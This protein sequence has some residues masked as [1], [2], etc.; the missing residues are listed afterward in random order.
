MSEIIGGGSEG[1]ASAGGN[2]I[3]DGSVE[4]FEED[5]LKMSL[6]VPVIVDFWAPWCGPCKQLTPALEKAVN[7]AGGSVRLV[8]IDIDKNQMLASQLRIQS[9]PT[10]YAFFQAQP[11]DGFMGA[12]PESEITAF[13]ERIKAVAANGGAPGSEPG[14]PDS[15][16][17]LAA[18]GEAFNAG[19]ISTG[20]QIF[21]QLAQSDPQNMAAIA[22]LAR[23]YVAMGETD[24]ARGILES[25]PEEKRSDPALTAVHA[26]ID[27]ASASSD[28][29]EVAELNTR[30]QAN[31]DD[32]D[33]RYELAEALIGAGDMDGAMNALFTLMEKDRAWHDEAARKKLLTIF[34]ALGPSDPL[35]KTGR[36]RMSSIL[37]S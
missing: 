24:Q 20:A 5:V 23:C 13:I 32:H 12:V 25:V 14:E 36:R 33:A 15:E 9:V 27:L 17:L 10:V 6:S 31:P 2:W 4:T 30:L 34:D 26:A 7:A 29:G 19:D 11:V 16:A 18:A 37:F 1:T 8:K 35:V 28:T 21:A 3:T 22:G